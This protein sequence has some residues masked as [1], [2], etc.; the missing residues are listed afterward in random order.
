MPFDFE[1]AAAPI[2]W[3]NHLLGIESRAGDKDGKAHP[4]IAVANPP[5]GLQDEAMYSPVPGLSLQPNLSLTGAHLIR[6]GGEKPVF[7]ATSDRPLPKALPT[8]H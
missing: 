5:G 1:F 7:F 4:V 2:I 8:A 6:A 3:R